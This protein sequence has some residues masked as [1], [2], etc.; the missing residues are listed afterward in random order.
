MAKRGVSV[1][2]DRD[3]DFLEVLLEN[4]A[5]YYDP[6]D[7]DDRVMVRYDND[8]NIIGFAVNGITKIGSSQQ[9]A[10]PKLY[11]LQEVASILQINLDT[12]RRYVRQRYL[13][14]TSLRPDGRGYFRVRHEDLMDFIGQREDSGKQS[15]PKAI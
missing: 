3:L 14:A 15:T 2:Y 8:G 5:G 7:V 11:T 12:V 4:K 13:K 10:I 9:A 6:L 1:R